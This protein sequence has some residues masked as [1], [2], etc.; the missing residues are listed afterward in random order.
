M[1]ETQ[2]KCVEVVEPILQESNSE[3]VA[4]Q[5]I[6]MLLSPIQEHIAAVDQAM[7]FP[8]VQERIVEEIQLVPQGHIARRSKSLMCLLPKVRNR[9]WKSPGSIFRR[10]CSS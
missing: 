2:K 6:H 7:A 9:V 3:R 10:G 5:I 1:R 4:E 8:Q